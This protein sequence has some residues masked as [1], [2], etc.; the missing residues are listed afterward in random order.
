M[1]Q[2]RVYYEGE[3][4]TG[5]VVTLPFDRS[6]YLLHV[7]RFKKGFALILFN[8]KGGQYRASVEEVLKKQIR[9]KVGEFEDL[10]L[11]SP[12]SIQ[13]AQGISKNEKMDLAIQKAVE[14]GVTSIT[15]VITEFCATKLNQERLG[16]RLEHWRNIIISACEQ[17][18]RTLLPVLNLPQEYAVWLEAQPFLSLLPEGRRCRAAAD[19][20][21]KNSDFQTS[22]I[23][24]LT[25][26]CDPN[27]AHS[28]GDLTPVQQVTL[29]VGP[30][31]GLSS[32]EI[33]A[34]E[35]RGCIGIRLGSR[36]L[37]TETAAVA[38]I[39]VVQSHWGDL[40]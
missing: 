15:P 6:H 24:N 12:L 17:S 2:S 27:A 11:E 30:E 21:P 35:K 13:L 32:A 23:P 37:R 39:S 28:I 5:Q 34:A 10:N 3:L 18:G 1:R 36:I 8:G 16:K 22:K 25:L 38:A 20:G 4:A 29:L 33:E 40:K 19:E 26:Y 14:L 9:L 31:G 7:L